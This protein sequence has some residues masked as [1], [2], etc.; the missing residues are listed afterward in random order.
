MERQGSFFIHA[1]GMRAANEDALGRPDNSLTFFVLLIQ[2]WRAEV[3]DAR[4][5]IIVQNLANSA[6]WTWNMNMDMETLHSCRALHRPPSTRFDQPSHR[7]GALDVLENG[8]VHVE[9]VFVRLFSCSPSSCSVAR[10]RAAQSAR[11]RA[12]CS[13]ARRRWVCSVIFKN[14]DGESEGEWGE[15]R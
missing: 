8:R 2:E 10:R 5:V 3:F 7:F 6:R 14:K 9:G 13:V 15:I 11:R 1:F 4:A 12:R